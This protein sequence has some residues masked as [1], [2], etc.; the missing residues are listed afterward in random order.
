MGCKRHSTGV[1]VKLFYYFCSNPFFT[2][3]FIIN[4]FISKGRN[5][6]YEN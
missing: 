5:N 6:L 2:K 1:I 3:P 4:I